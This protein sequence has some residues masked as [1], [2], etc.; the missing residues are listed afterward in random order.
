MFFLSLQNPLLAALLRLSS[1]QKTDENG[2]NDQNYNRPDD[3]SK[4]FAWREASLIHRRRLQII[5]GASAAQ[6]TLRR[7]RI[8]IISYR[9]SSYHRISRS[10]IDVADPSATRV[11][12]HH[13]GCLQR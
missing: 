2:H 11:F 5:V 8:H 13:E 1:S 10:D 9:S 7:L 6:I 12:I 3:I 4:H